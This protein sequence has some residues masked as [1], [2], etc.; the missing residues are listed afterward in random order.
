MIS[1]PE[2]DTLFAAVQTGCPREVLEKLAPESDLP[3]PARVLLGI[4]A[5]EAGDPGR[6]A[7]ELESVLQDQPDNPP[8]R[9]HLALAKYQQ[10]QPAECARLLKAGPLLP[11]PAFL[12]RFLRLFWPM[13]FENPAIRLAGEKPVPDEWPLKAEVQ[14]ALANPESLSPGAKKSLAAKLIKAAQKA[15]KRRE[16]LVAAHLF[17]QAAQ[18]TPD[19]ADIAFTLAHLHLELGAF[20]EALRLMDELNTRAVAAKIPL[21]PQ[22]ITLHAWALHANGQHK[23]ALAMLSRTRPQGPDDFLAHILAA[24]CW[25]AL[26][27]RDN[28]QRNYDQAFGPF[29][30]ESW[31]GFTKPYL[32]KVNVW[33]GDA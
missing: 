12:V 2:I 27:E 5:L 1:A 17:T 21:Q 29:F 8:A 11:Q 24:V 13:Q 14:E 20:G 30:I 6:S 16:R 4:A 7:R 19:N 9:L 22:A 23:A 25:D 18:L 31:L 3:L 26:G 28:A 15:D 32:D 33:L 10:G